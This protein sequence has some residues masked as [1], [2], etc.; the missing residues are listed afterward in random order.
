MDEGTRDRLARCGQE[1]VSALG[2]DEHN[3]APNDV[4]EAINRIRKERGEF[5][6]KA[7]AA[8]AAKDREIAELR[9]H[10]DT[11]MIHELAACIERAEAAEA[12][13]ERLR[14]QLANL[15]TQPAQ[16]QE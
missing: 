9:K 10:G 8:T 12:E 15:T 3:D 6:L 13:V 4:R 2:L 5:E 7:I 16:S 11:G 1:A 14:K